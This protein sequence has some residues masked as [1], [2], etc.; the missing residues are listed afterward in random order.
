[1]RLAAGNHAALCPTPL[2]VRYGR[3]D[4]NQQ[5]GGGGGGGRGGGDRYGGGGGGGGMG[6]GYDGAG[7]GAGA[8]MA[9]AMAG[10]GMGGMGGMG[11]MMGNSMVQLVPVQLPN[12]QVSSCCLRDGFGM[13]AGRQVEACAQVMKVVARVHAGCEFPALHPTLC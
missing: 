2:Q 7:A 5:Q 13:D 6:G 12:G 1:M 8:G 9:G 10:M 4:A 3:A 11:V